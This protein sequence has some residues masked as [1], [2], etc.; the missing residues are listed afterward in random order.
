MLMLMNSLTLVNQLDKGEDMNQV[1]KNFE[2]NFPAINENVIERNIVNNSELI[3]TLKDGSIF[4]YDDTEKSIRAL[5]KDKDNLSEDEW[6]K[7]FGKRLRKKMN[8]VGISQNDLALE[9]D[10]TQPQV[11][12][13]VNGKVTPSFY[14]IDKI[15]KLLKCSIDDLTY[16]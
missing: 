4:L 3:I 11:S 15:A 16:R 9:L 7:E 12:C 8:R 14:I 13:Y 6:R 10:I 1:V 2:L 5:P